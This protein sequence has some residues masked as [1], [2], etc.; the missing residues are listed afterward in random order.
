MRI[1]R[2]GGMLG[3]AL[4]A[5]VGSASAADCANLKGLK[6]EFTEISI[7]ET[8]TSGV[9]EI[10]EIASLHDL[11]PFC[12]VQGILRPTGDSKILFEVWL[13]EKD[14]NGRE[15]GVGNG[16]FAGS[17]G[18]DGLATYLKR[19]YRTPGRRH[20]CKLGLRAS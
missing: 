18:Y 16:G 3:V 19:G 17:I 11:P 14:W 10:P 15:L 20:G 8:V 7:A 13:P 6:L 12:R 2:A 1:V 4:L 5:A 9:L